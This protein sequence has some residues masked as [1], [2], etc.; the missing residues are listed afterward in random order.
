M[1]VQFYKDVNDKRIDFVVMVCRYQ[2]QWVFV[3]HKKRHT[4][5]VPGGHREANETVLHAA[6]RELEEETGAIS[7]QLFPICIYSV[8]GKNRVNQN[9]DELFGQLYYGD[10]CQFGDLPDYEIEQVVLF[11]ELPTQWTYPQIQPLLIQKVI[12]SI[13]ID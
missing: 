6:R 10:I 5:E 3:K 12:D 1:K 8:T 4:Y 13:N 11:N 9:G 7:Y 2:G